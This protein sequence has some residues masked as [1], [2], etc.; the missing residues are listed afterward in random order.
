[1]KCRRIYADETG[2][3]HFADIDIPLVPMELFPGVPPIYLSA[4]H[5]ATSVRFAWVP[6]GMREAGWHTTPVRQLVIWLTGWVEFEAAC[7]NFSL[8]STST[9]SLAAPV[10]T[11]AKAALPPTIPLPTTPIFIACSP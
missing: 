4:E 8:T 9:I 2:D 3:S 10:M 1:M 6:S 7:A 11:A 5:T